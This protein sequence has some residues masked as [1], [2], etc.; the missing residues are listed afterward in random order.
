V[1]Q[2]HLPLGMGSPWW[3]GIVVLFALSVTVIVTTHVIRG[4][5]MTVTVGWVLSLKAIKER[6]REK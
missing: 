4:G 1:V 6:E 5:E 2:T 3:L